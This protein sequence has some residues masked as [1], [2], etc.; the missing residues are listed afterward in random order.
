ME[1]DIHPIQERRPSMVRLTELEDNLS[2]KDETEERR[3]LHNNRRSRPYHLSIKTSDNLENS[4]RLPC[5][6]TTT[7]QIKRHIRKQLHRTTTGTTRRRRDIWNPDHPKPSKMRTGISISHQ[8][9]R[10]PNFGR[11]MGARII[12]FKRRRHPQ[13]IQTA[14]WTQMIRHD[15]NDK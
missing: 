2:Q 3:T 8:M 4:Q 6:F 15:A 12:L 14:T 10:L 11:I 13:T 5:N 9:D 7:I 1:I